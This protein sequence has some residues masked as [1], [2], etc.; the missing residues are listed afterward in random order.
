MNRPPQTRL[1]IATE[2]DEKPR[3]LRILFVCVGNI[4]RSPTAEIIF[5]RAAGQTALGDSVEVASAGTLAYHAG[6]APDPR[7]QKAAARRGFDLSGVRSRPVAP[8]DFTD[9]DRI[10]AMDRHCLER[11]RVICPPEHLIR[12]G[13]FMDYAKDFDGDDVPDP[14]YGSGDDFDRV[15]ALVEDAVTGLLDNLRQ[16]GKLAR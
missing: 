16:T 15:V 7:M 1:P 4:C 10:L 3:M 8:A 11:L 13:L 6:E 9:F 5:R 12:L 14:Y 2:L